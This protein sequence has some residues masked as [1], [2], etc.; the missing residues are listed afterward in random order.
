MLKR[1]TDTL[2]DEVFFICNIPD[3]FALLSAG[4]KMYFRAKT[5]IQV[6][7]C[8]KKL[9]ICET[10]KRLKFWTLANIVYSG[11]VTC[12]FVFSK[13][14]ENQLIVFL[15]RDW[16]LSRNRLKLGLL[17]CIKDISTKYRNFRHYNI[18]L[19][20]QEVSKTM[21]YLLQFPLKATLCTDV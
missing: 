17:K 11:K 14:Q 18:D 8:I 6:C 13:Y 19:L 15:W 4:C 3:C 12:I 9:K 16:I 21:K 2:H 5:K 10:H 20:Q 1:F 7:D